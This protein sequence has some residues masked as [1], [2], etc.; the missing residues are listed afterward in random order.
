MKIT[1]E[2]FNKLKALDRAI[3]DEHG[4]EILNPVPAEFPSTLQRPTSMIE[5]M[6]RVIKQELD[7]QAQAQGM[8]SFKEADDFDVPDDFDLEVMS[9]YELTTLQEEYIEENW[10]DEVPEESKESPKPPD[11]PEEPSEPV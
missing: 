5:Q 11:V 1:K 3:I 10:P 7:L 6:K 4:R 9:K 8:E 2:T